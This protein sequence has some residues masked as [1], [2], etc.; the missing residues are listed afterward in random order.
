MD[1]VSLLYV[2]TLYHRTSVHYHIK[3][4]T[5]NSGKLSKNKLT[6]WKKYECKGYGPI[7]MELRDNF[8]RKVR[9]H[10]QLFIKGK[11]ISSFVTS[12]QVW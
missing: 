3:E 5:V 10:G 4:N 1:S 11:L 6:A 8:K 2:S 12:W 9:G 7:D